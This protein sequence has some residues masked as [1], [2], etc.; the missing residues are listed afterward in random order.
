MVLPLLMYC[1]YFFSVFHQTLDI[2][3]P[4]PKMCTYTWTV[5]K[6]QQWL[7]GKYKHEVVEDNFDIIIIKQLIILIE[8]WCWFV[9][10]RLCGD[11]TQLVTLTLFRLSCFYHFLTLK[12][13]RWLW[14]FVM[15]V[16]TFQ[17][18]FRIPLEQLTHP[19]FELTETCTIKSLI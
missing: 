11:I 14:P 13:H 15:E 7:P 18:H 1:K 8:F 17:S 9:D 6:W 3:H 16:Y 19:C 12:L 5:S 10:I 4:E 2:F